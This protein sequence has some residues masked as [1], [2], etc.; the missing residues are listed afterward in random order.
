[1]PRAAR[2]LGAVGSTLALGDLGHADRRGG[3]A[4]GGM[5]P[6]GAGDGV[7]EIASLLEHRHGPALRRRGQ[8]RLARG[9]EE[10]AR[11]AG[12]RPRRSAR[13]LVTDA[14]AERDLLD[15][16][17]LQESSWFRDEATWTALADVVLPAAL[18]RDPQLEVWSAGCAHGQEAWSLA[19]LL[20][21]LG[22][23]RARVVASDV[24]G[25]AVARAAAGSLRRARAAR[26]SRP[27]A[28]AP[29]PPA[30]RRLGGGAAAARARAASP[31]TTSRRMRRR[32][33]PPDA[34]SC[35]AGTS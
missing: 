21:E 34:A 22:A 17:T 16:V 24:S 1:M 27:S 33:R 12:T 6:G 7:G 25:A 18:A 8:R 10:T 26:A 4:G 14:V 11:R 9:V 5:T 28:G 20:D 3:P 23:Q 30:S 29:R 19:M 15:R 2:E 31:A 35:C 13:R 32:S